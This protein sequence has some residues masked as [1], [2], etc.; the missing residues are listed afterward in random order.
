MSN[1]FEK[2]DKEYQLLAE[3]VHTSFQ[4]K[5]GNEKQNCLYDVVNQEKKD[6]SLRP[7]QI[8]SVSLHYSLLTPEQEKAVVTT[9]YETLYIGCIGSIS[10]IFDGDALPAQRGCYAQ[11]WSV[12]EV[13]GVYTEDILPYR[14]T[15]CN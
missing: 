12:R 7:N 2:N 13:L 8:Y 3:S 14:N 1:C 11:A 15:V 5:F 9:V 6:D 10:E 4:E